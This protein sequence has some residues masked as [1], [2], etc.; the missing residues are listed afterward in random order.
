MFRFFTPAK[1]AN[2][3]TE[4][5]STNSVCV[6]LLGETGRAEVGRAN[7]GHKNLFCKITNPMHNKFKFG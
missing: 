4:E 3:N 5:F 1:W 7:V 6:T 2:K